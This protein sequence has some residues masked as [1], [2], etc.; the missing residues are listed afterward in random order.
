MTSP[1]ESGV[2]GT[3]NLGADPFQHHPF[4]DA[5]AWPGFKW[6][7]SSPNTS[8]VVTYSF[9]TADATWVAD[10]ANG[11]P[12]SGFAP[13]TEEQQAAVRQALALWSEVANITFVEVAE[14][15]SNV[16]DIRF[17]NSAAVTGAAQAYM[18]YVDGVSEHPESGDIWLNSQ[19][20][21]NLQLQPGQEGFAT[22]LQAIGHALGLDDPALN[23]PSNPNEVAFVG[24]YAELNTS[25]YSIMSS[26][27]EPSTLAYAS[28]PQAADILAIQYIYGRNMTTRTG[29][30]V[31]QFSA[32]EQVN[33]TIWDAG[34]IDT[35]DFSNQ[36]GDAQ[37]Y[38]WQVSYSRFCEQDGTA[39]LVGIATEAQIENAIGGSGNDIIYGNEL[40]NYLQGGDGN[41]SVDGFEGD[42]IVEGGSGD[43]ELWGYWGNDRLDGGTG[44]DRM[45]GQWGDDVYVVDDYA[46]QVIENVDE[47]YDTIESTITYALAEDSNVEALKLIG[48]A[49]LNASGNS[50]ENTL[51]GNAGNNFLTGGAGADTLDGGAGAD[52]LI[53]GEG[54]DTY[55]IDS[56]LDV[57]DEEL[58]ADDG[59]GV[60]S[61][62]SI[63]LAILA[64]GAL[65]N[66]VLLGTAVKAIGNAANNELVGNDGANILDGRAGAD[67][68]IGG[69]GNDTYFVDNVGDQI[70][71]DIADT[72][73]GIDTVK[74]AIDFSLATLDNIEKLT[75][76]AGF[77]D[78]NGTGNALNNRLVGNEGANV[79]D[80]G[81]GADAMVGGA[82]NDYYYVDNI[83]DT[84]KETLAN[85]LGGGIDTVESL[86]TYSLAN[87]DNID[88]LILSGSD[89]I[90][91]TGNALDNHVIGN[92]NA[93]RL[94]GG[95]GND[96]LIGGDG[97]DTLLGGLGDDVLQ[98]GDGNDRMIGGDG[99]DVFDFN[100]L[101]ELGD[102]DVIT[103]FQKGADLIDL[104]HIIT[105][106]TGIFDD[107]VSFA[108]AG[109]STNV[110]VDADGLG[111]GSAVLLTSLLNVQLT[112][113]DSS[114]FIMPNPLA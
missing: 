84:V 89:D 64:G 83:G 25:Q 98:A 6:G 100:S 32:T 63:N 10:Y 76:L 86:V 18:P 66:A 110:F 45:L 82:G 14:T 53:G 31:Y 55:V 90:N 58:N 60:R 61:T 70:I 65:E 104:S 97:N 107:Y 1:Y 46:D 5:L 57:I 3:F 71:E 39:S 111:S 23:D 19:Y 113:A 49:D 62:I 8:A 69:Q 75:L 67:I 68:L 4:I 24:Q 50:F 102:H 44:I 42:D 99:S 92:N 96:L 12:S 27:A 2:I 9:P 30:D 22:I 56:A 114:S 106:Y 103:D 17:A 72:E 88:H 26:V 36:T 81:A 29:D 21:P 80:G 35:F 28:T 33:K 78:I 94:N 79:L 7:A 91:G 87:R 108:S 15:A 101:S 77:G 47:G 95:A 37:I 52:T 105:G 20:E 41:D 48:D 112:N 85:T 34:G 11:E 59:D 73:G 16:G 109:T 43:D 51:I 74:S 93:N 38:L 54:N 13:F 40:D